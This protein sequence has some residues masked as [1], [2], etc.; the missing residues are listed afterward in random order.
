M[1]LV[2]G[3]ILLASSGDADVPQPHPLQNS[4]EPASENTPDRGRYE[5]L[6]TR[7]AITG[8]IPRNIRNRELRFVQERFRSKVA[9]GAADFDWRPRGPYN[10]GGR[11]RAFALDVTD[12]NVILAG[13]VSGGLWRSVDAGLSWTKTTAPELPQNVT[14]IVQDT[15]PGQTNTW[16]FGTGESWGSGGVEGAGIF[17][18]DDGGRSWSALPSSP[19]PPEDVG[20]FAEILHFAMNPLEEGIEL[21]AAT[22]WGVYRTQDGG[23]TW[24]RIIGDEPLVFDSDIVRAEE[25]G[26][27][28]AVTRVKGSESPHLSERTR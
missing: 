10:V 5:W 20:G 1:A 9:K 6:L 14:A 7:S 13:V 22:I 21:Y 12:E 3:C 15:R 26:V 17:R 27:M 23:E 4:R 8:E 25:S 18:S 11:T 16:Y 24:E 2:L 28:Y 19:R